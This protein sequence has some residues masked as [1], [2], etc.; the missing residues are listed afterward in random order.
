MYE[1][2]CECICESVHWSLEDNLQELALSFNCAFWASNS[3][4][5]V[6]AASTFTLCTTF[7]ANL[8]NSY[9]EKYF[10]YL[11][12]SPSIYYFVLLT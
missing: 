6:E 1:Y 3:G 8:N 5:L 12:C 4:C 7:L 10:V 9:V 2:R 11:L